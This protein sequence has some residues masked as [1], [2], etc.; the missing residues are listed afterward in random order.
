MLLP[1][2]KKNTRRLQKF[3]CLH[4]S[5]EKAVNAYE[6]LAKLY[7]FINIEDK[8][9]QV[10]CII[11]LG[12]DGFMLECLH[13]YM[14]LDIPFYGINCGTVGFLLNSYRE[15]NLFDRISRAHSAKLH[16]LKLHA[17]TLD[18]SEYN[19]IAFNEVSLL[20]ETRQAAKIKVVVDHVVR[21]D[22]MIC[23][24]IMVAT[25]AG[26][27]AYNFS[28]QGPIIPLGANILALTPISPFRPRRWQGALLPH[29]STVFL[30]IIESKKRP[31]SAVAD[32]Q[33]VRDVTHVEIS[34]YRKSSVTLLFDPEESLHERVVREQF[35]F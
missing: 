21:I 18:G 2:T 24:G 23:D 7:E 26:S 6:S 29:T 28:A 31:V 20:R 5:S 30:E 17:R 14:V 33:E 19:K 9:E 8:P 16:P 11:A 22:E 25:P 4:D 27:T 15:D 10:D 1:S 34:E 12:G 13:K 35:V 32:F 3:A